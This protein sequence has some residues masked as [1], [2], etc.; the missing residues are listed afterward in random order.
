[1]A[2]VGVLLFY[3]YSINIKTTKRLRCNVY[4]QK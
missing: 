4:R 1:M 3:F 2:G